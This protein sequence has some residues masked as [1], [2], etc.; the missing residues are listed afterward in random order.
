MVIKM[1]LIDLLIS[2]F[3]III[4]YN[5]ITHIIR[6]VIIRILL[7]IINLWITNIINVLI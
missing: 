2:V 5:P 4:N 3:T 1:I 6:I 7:I